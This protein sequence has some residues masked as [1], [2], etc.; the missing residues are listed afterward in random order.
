MYNGLNQGWSLVCWSSW[1][2]GRG[3][4]VDVEGC[5]YIPY[6]WR[7]VVSSRI[8]VYD[9]CCIRFQFLSVP[10]RTSTKMERLMIC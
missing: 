4:G 7:D 2:I 1:V 10:D 3:G 5:V 6:L 9:P 8:L